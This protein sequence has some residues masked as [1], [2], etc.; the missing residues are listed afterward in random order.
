MP[1]WVYTYSRPDP[2]KLG[3]LKIII[4]TDHYFGSI[5]RIFSSAT[6]EILAICKYFRGNT[7]LKGQSSSFTF[8][9]AVKPNIDRT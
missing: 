7:E 5:K 6:S 4:S 8:T 1:V 2:T 3:N 9:L